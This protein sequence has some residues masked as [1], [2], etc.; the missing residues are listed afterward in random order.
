MF[1]DKLMRDEPFS[2]T[3]RSTVVSV[4]EYDVAVFMIYPFVR[5]WDEMPEGFLAS[6]AP[7][8]STIT[9][10]TWCNFEIT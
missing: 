6:S 2:T 1:V 5:G 4:E 7:T 8:V 10:H 9:K 3:N